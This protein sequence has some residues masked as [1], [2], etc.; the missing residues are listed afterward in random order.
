MRMLSLF[1]IRGGYSTLID[2]LTLGMLLVVC[3]CGAPLSHSILIAMAVVNESVSR[4][5]N[6]GKR[7]NT[8]VQVVGSE[9]W[10]HGCGYRDWYTPI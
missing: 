3:C 10:A 7:D 6:R 8:I 5:G 9:H 2:N 4:V 1:R